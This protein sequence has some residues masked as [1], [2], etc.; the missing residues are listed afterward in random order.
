MK[1]GP[2][3]ALFLWQPRL[4][5]NQFG[6]ARKHWHPARCLHVLSGRMILAAEDA[7]ASPS[8][9]RSITARSIGFRCVLAPPAR[10]TP[11]G[12]APYSARERAFPSPDPLP[13]LRLLRRAASPPEP[14]PA[15]AAWLVRGSGLGPSGFGRWREARR[16]KETTPRGGNAGL[17]DSS[18]RS[19][20][21]S[22]G[23]G[24]GDLPATP[25]CHPPDR[26]RP[27]GPG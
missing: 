9:P 14:H 7:V 23:C 15:A 25:A 18:L 8:C 22:A 10:L 26:S 6:G 5:A 17:G 24:P 27:D 3:T 16:T 12:T 2:R 20:R 19:E 4:V 21:R 1:R 13:S 11:A